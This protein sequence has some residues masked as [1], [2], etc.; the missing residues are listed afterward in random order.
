ME[1]V[2]TEGSEE[3]ADPDPARED[4]RLAREDQRPL[5]VP[6][7]TGSQGCC[8]LRLG[9]TPSGH[10]T[11]VAFTSRRLLAAVFGEGQ[12]WV[13]LAEP[14]LRAMA[15]PLGTSLVTVDP[16]VAVAPPAAPGAVPL[17]GGPLFAPRSPAVHRS[18]GR[19]KV[20]PV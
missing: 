17:L 6:V 20:L 11:A 13:V 5:Y 3:C 12:Q 19:S 1:L 8:L 16:K 2:S 9:R 14:A 7:R 4:R 18:A 10:R 15:E